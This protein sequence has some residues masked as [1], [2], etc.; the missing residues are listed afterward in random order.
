MVLPLGEEL[1]LLGELA[2]SQRDAFKVRVNT[3]LSL[4]YEIYLIL[5]PCSLSSAELLSAI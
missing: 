2:Q 5:S 3:G 1:V 4:D